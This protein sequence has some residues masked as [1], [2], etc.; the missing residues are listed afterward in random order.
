MAEFSKER[1]IQNIKLSKAGGNQKTKLCFRLVRIFIFL[2]GD[3]SE[4]LKR[5]SL[6]FFS[7]IIFLD[8]NATKSVVSSTKSFSL[9]MKWNWSFY[10]IVFLVR[11]AAKS[12]VFLQNHFIVRNATKSLFTRTKFNKKALIF[13]TYNSL[14][15]SNIRLCKSS[16]FLNHLAFR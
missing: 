16:C 12:L 4:V 1:I 13:S 6:C 7:K 10:K 3:C 15:L 9:Y 5:K 8:R 14:G 11:K 2:V